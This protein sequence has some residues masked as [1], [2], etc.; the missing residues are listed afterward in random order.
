MVFLNGISKS[1][2]FCKT[3]NTLLVCDTQPKLVLCRF[4]PHLFVFNMRR[5]P[6]GEDC[7][8]YFKLCNHIKFAVGSKNFVSVVN[9][10]YWISGYHCAYFI[11]FAHLVLKILNCVASSTGTL[12]AV[13]TGGQRPSL[14][15]C[16]SREKGPVQINCNSA[17]R[18]GKNSCFLEV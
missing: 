16:L 12:L 3:E 5:S 18:L 10:L 1:S 8:H 4:L 7:R 6:N 11:L 9:R 2:L 15:I 17:F 14:T 13:G